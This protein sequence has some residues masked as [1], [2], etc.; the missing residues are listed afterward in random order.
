MKSLVTCFAFVLVSALRLLGGDAFADNVNHVV[1]ECMRKC[2][3]GVVTSWADASEN[4]RDVGAW[5]RVLPELLSDDKERNNVIFAL[6]ARCCLF[7]PMSI[8]PILQRGNDTPF[9]RLSVDNRARFQTDIPTGILSRYAMSGTS[10]VVSVRIA[11]VGTRISPAFVFVGISKFGWKHGDPIGLDDIEVVNTDFDHMLWRGG[12]AKINAVRTQNADGKSSV[13][14][15]NPM[16]AGSSDHVTYHMA[17]LNG[18][19]DGSVY[20]LVSGGVGGGLFEFVDFPKYERRK[21]TIGAP[22]EGEMRMRVRMLYPFWR[23]YRAPEIVKLKELVDRVVTSGLP[24]DIPSGGAVDSISITVAYK[25]GDKVLSWNRDLIP[26]NK[27][28]SVF[29]DIVKQCGLVEHWS[30]QPPGAESGIPSGKSSQGSGSGPVNGIQEAPIAPP[31][32]IPKPSPSP[33]AK[34]CAP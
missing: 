25:N 19:E 34:S 18:L 8:L 10:S 28:E 16:P 7:S 15:D 12:P 2:D 21:L 4:H 27:V 33:P 1:D 32:N 24:P 17:G 14:A 9:G 6:Y 30:E 31:P 5:E 3:I 11:S 13:P 26:D 22:V 23:H 20:V 29:T